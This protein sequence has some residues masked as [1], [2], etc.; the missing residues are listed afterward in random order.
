[1]QLS[2]LEKQLI[3]LLIILV[4]VVYRQRSGVLKSLTQSIEKL[5]A[6]MDSLVARSAEEKGKIYHAIDSLE[7]DMTHERGIDRERIGKQEAVCNTHRENCAE[8][9]R[10][11]RQN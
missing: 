10:T 3:A 7:R 8:R 4:G 9:R 2:P 5:N 11:E 6:T 1:M